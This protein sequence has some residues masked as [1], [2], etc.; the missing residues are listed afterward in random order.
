MAGYYLELIYRVSRTVDITVFASD[1]D[2]QYEII[3]QA[4]MAG[5]ASAVP[6]RSANIS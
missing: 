5:G 2:G 4:I 3:Y 6:V 1:G